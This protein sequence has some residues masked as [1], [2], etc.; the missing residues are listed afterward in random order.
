MY[1]F[2]F[3][4]ISFVNLPNSM[5]QHENFDGEFRLIQIVT[6]DYNNPDHDNVTCEITSFTPYET[7]MFELRQDG[8]YDYNCKLIFLNFS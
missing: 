4:P 3:Q 1:Y 6:Y 2:M 8:R 5:T 7:N